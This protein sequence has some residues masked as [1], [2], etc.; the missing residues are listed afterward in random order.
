MEI[1]RNTLVTVCR[2]TQIEWNMRVSMGIGRT[3][4]RR[5]MWNSEYHSKSRPPV[6]LFVAV[7]MRP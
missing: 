6:V 7:T 1:W 2:I 5:W 4:D 3:C